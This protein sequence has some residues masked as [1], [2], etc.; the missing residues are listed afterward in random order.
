MTKVFRLGLIINPFA[1]L[2]GPAGLKG[3]DHPDTASLA[4]ALG[5]KSKVHDRVIEVLEG[6]RQ[7]LGTLHIVT[8]SGLMGEAACHDFSSVFTIETVYTSPL[9]STAQDT[10]E[11]AKR[12]VAQSIDLLLFAGGDGTA[13]DICTAIGQ[14]QPVLGLPSGVKMHSGVF[15]VTPRAVVSVVESLVQRRLVAARLAEVRDIDEQAFGQGR[16]CTQHFGELLIPDDQL[17]VQSVKCS[18]LLDDEIMLN[19]LCA[20]MVEELV[21]NTLY[22]LG[23]GGT[24]KVLKSA[25]GIAQ[26]TL[27]GVDV[28]YQGQVV[29]LDVHERQLFELVQQYPQSILVLSI[30]GGQGVILGRGNQQLSPRIIEYIGLDRIKLIA[31]QQKILAL[32]GKPLCVDSG[33]DQLDRR[34]SGYHKIICGYDDAL[35]YEVR[36]LP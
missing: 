23:S 22:V 35:L 26:P 17:L 10:I 13:R 3:S 19:D 30:I 24:L 6:L 25:M 33:A 31:T 15:A 14:N 32:G 1:G 9:P 34:L 7:R 21:D 16:V 4:A 28:W 2:G 36:Y 8:A 11:A 20:F 18:G 12:I 29:A 5:V 27:L